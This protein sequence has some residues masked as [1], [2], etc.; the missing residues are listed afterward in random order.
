MKYSF[1]NSWF[2]DYHRD[3]FHKHLCHLADQQINFLEI[4]AHEGRSTT[5]VIDNY[6][7]HKNSKL[8]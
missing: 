5:W 8:S 2:S 7:H 3:L 6:L 4:G 1:T